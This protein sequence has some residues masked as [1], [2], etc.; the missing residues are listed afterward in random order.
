[1]STGNVVIA[2]QCVNFRPSKKLPSRMPKYAVPERLK[3]CVVDNKDV[4]TIVP[5]LLKVSTVQCN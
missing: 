3:K 5:C 1:M 4:T 2:K